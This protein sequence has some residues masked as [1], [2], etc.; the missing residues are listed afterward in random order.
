MSNSVRT[1]LDKDVS[2]YFSSNSLISFVTIGVDQALNRHHHKLRN[3]VT[4]MDCS[5]FGVASRSAVANRAFIKARAPR[6]TIHR[7]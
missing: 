4:G 6:K 3:A 5:P 2:L 1:V 7:L